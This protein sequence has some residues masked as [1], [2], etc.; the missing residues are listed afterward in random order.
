MDRVL[1]VGFGNP[2][3]GDDGAGPAVIHQIRLCGG[4]P[5]NRFEDGGSDVLALPTLWDGEQSVWII[6]AV[7]GSQPAGKI[8]R[9]RHEQLLSL[10][11][12]SASC[13]HLS[14]PECLRWILHG[15]PLM[16][17]VRFRLWGIEPAMIAFS[18]ALSEAVA[19][20]VAAVANEVCQELGRRRSRCD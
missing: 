10:P 9:L 8:H 12:R 14:L 13:H 19:G 1:V 4:A 17:R 2:M 16:G 15:H 7:S 20:A 18:P 6:D 5:P 11:Q 3:M